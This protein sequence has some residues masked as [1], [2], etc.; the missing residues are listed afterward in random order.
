MKTSLRFAAALAAFIVSA[1]ALAADIPTKAPS[2]LGGY[3]TTRCGFYYGIGTG[4]SAGAVDGAVVG[5][6]IVQGDLDA[7]VGYTCPFL[8]SAF[9]F[10]E[11]SAG[12]SNLNGNV[13][14][15]ALSG[16]L[17]FIQRAGA[18]SPINKLFNPFSASLS[19][20]SLPALP[21]GVTA[22][23]AN[24]YFFAGLVEQ[25]ITAQVAPGQHTKQWVI[26]PIV[27]LGLLT[28]LNDGVVVDTWAGWQMNSQSFCPNGNGACAKLGN[29]GRVGVSFKY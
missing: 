8:S 18:G 23:P 16:P 25:D 15:L 22:G 11:A 24:G 29:T 17:I 13:N 5:T 27:G 26:A 2:L 12:Y 7:M 28:R 9:W 20:P 14:G 3:P 10:V 1:P 19:L 4:G 21:N 6:Q